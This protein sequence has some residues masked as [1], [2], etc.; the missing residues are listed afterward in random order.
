IQIASDQVEQFLVA[1]VNQLAR[2]ADDEAQIAVGAFAAAGEYAALVEEP[3]RGGT[4]KADEGC[5]GD[6]AVEPRMDAD[7]RRRSDLAQVREERIGASPFRQKAHELC[8][9]NGRD[10][11]GGLQTAAVA[12]PYADDTTLAEFQRLDDGARLDHAAALLDD[13]H[14]AGAVEIA[15]PDLR[16]DEGGIGAT[17]EKRALQN[18]G[19]QSRR[20]EFGVFVERRDR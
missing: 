12:Q 5:L 4:D 9:R 15:Q 8:G 6:F 3:L 20:S 18:L 13:A 16:V 19:E 11:I 14:G 7:N 17:R 2:A 1:R 10:E